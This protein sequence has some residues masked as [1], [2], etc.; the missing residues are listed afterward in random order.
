MKGR[1]APADG[2]AHGQRHAPAVRAGSVLQRGEPRGRVGSAPRARAWPGQPQ[3]QGR[4]DDNLTWAELL[5]KRD[6]RR[7]N[8]ED[9]L[10]RWIKA[11]APPATVNRKATVLRAVLSKACERHELTEHPMTGIKPQQVDAGDRDGD[12]HHAQYRRPPGP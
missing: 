1:A 11:G 12:L 6:I 4:K 8:I 5:D 7:K 10:A 3:R 9:I 2:P